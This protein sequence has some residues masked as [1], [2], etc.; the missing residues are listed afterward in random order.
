[1]FYTGDSWRNALKIPVNDPIFL[2]LGQVS[3]YQVRHGKHL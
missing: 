2:V 3:L 1:M